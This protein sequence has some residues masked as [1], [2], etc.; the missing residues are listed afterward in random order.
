MNDKCYGILYIPK[1]NPYG[2]RIGYKKEYVDLNFT[3]DIHNEENICR[4]IRDVLKINNFSVIWTF[5]D[6][7]HFI[8]LH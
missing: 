5:L 1:Y 7:D 4:Y 3:I 2:E 6:F 8:D